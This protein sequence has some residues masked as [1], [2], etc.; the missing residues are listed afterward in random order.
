MVMRRSTARGLPDLLDW[1]ESLPQL[2]A[3]TNRPAATDVRGMRLEEF[4]EGG[5]YV[6]RAEL[7]GLDPETDI[8]I[9]VENSVLT[10]RAE[11]RQ[12][13]HDRGSTEFHYGHFE[14]RVLLPEGTDESDIT[15]G[16]DA[17]VLEVS[18]P[19]R[20]QAAQPRS[21]P[22]QRT[23]SGEQR[24]GTLGKQATGP[25]ETNRPVP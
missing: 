18:V 1:A 21:I 6:V 4:V 8:D 23:A 2:L 15:A 20:E 16:Y 19:V 17:G 12:T 14:R 5:T 3:L 24:T 9:E 22:V 10:I 13:K 25:E 11:R 7:P